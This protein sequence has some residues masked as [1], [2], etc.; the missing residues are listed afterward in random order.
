MSAMDA[1]FVGEA[2]ATRAEAPLAIDA[3]QHVA[4]RDLGMNRLGARH[5]ARGDRGPHATLGVS[6]GEVGRAERLAVPHVEHA[7]VAAIAHL[8]V[9]AA[10]LDVG[11]EKAAVRLDGETVGCAAHT[12][13]QGLPAIRIDAHEGGAVVGDPERAVGLGEDALGAR[14]VTT[15][16]TEVPGLQ[17]ERERSQRALLD[18]KVPLLTI[19]Q[20]LA[21]LKD[22]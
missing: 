14:Q 8:A 16:G 4:V 13:H 2:E 17:L 9:E 22:I 11:E 3:A 1:H 21:A 20:F 10:L 19:R 6:V 15:D 7:L 18:L 12:A 5:G